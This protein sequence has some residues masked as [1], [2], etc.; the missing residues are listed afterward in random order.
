MRVSS[1]GGGAGFGVGAATE[2]RR[3]SA[4]LFGGTG[5][6]G[7]A[8]GM[9]TVSRVGSGGRF[10]GAGAISESWMIVGSRRIGSGLWVMVQISANRPTASNRATAT[11]IAKGNRSRPNLHHG[12]SLKRLGA[13]ASFLQTAGIHHG[14]RQP[15]LRRRLVLRRRRCVTP[16]RAATMQPSFTDHCLYV[17]R[18]LAPRPSASPARRASSGRTWNSTSRSGSAPRCYPPAPGRRTSGTAAPAAG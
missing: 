1:A 18:T 6:G 2:S 10:G 17:R 14:W 7:G 13:P 11:A 15:R 3:C 9:R 5:L 4:G 16:A 8:C 12:R